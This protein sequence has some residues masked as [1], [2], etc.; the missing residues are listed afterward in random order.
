MAGPTGTA[1]IDQAVE[2]FLAVSRYTL[3]ERTGPIRSTIEVES[4]PENAGPSY[5]IPKYGQVTTYALTDGVDM[6]Q[7][8]QITDTLMTITPAEFGAQVVLTDMM[9]MTVRDSFFEVASKILRDSFD[10]QQDQTL[11]D[12]M[13]NYS[14]ALGTAGTALT[15][16]HVMAATAAIADAGRAADG[17]AGRGGEVAPTPYYGAFSPPQIHSLNKTLVGQV[18]GAV[19]LSSG[20]TAAMVSPPNTGNANGFGGSFTI[21]GVGITIVCDTNFLKDANDDIKGGVYSKSAQILVELGKAPGVE[22]QRDSSLRAWE[23]NYVGRWARGEYNDGWGREMLFD[24]ARP[25]S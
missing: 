16:G 20:G 23:L 25:S 4:L 15:I 11:C 18:A 1:Q 19:V 5:L 7:A 6:A 12:D 22:K 14:I 8:Q 9:M 13:D 17:T 2:R 24:S 3:Q 21:P 10:R